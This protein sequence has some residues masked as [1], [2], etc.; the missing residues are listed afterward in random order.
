[1]VQ[2]YR[3]YDFD[4]AVEQLTRIWANALGIADDA[5]DVT[6]DRAGPPASG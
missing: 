4:Q 6:T 1:L 2:G 5:G 3:E